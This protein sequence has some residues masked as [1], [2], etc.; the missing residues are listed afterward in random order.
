MALI[1]TVR[2][3]S[4]TRPPNGRLGH[5]TGRLQDRRERQLRASS[6]PMRNDL[7]CLLLLADR[8]KTDILH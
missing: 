3:A 6:S 8:L 4:V 7:Q 1:D 2:L 5:D